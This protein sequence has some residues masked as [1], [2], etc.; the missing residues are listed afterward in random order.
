[1]AEGM[2]GGG[3]H[4]W[5]GLEGACMVGD[6]HGWGGGCAWHGACMAGGVHS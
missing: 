5:M 2:C 3:M 4:G 1:M 6:I